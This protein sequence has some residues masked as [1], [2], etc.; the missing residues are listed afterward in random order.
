MWKA[1]GIQGDLPVWK[2]DCQKGQ[3]EL[4]LAPNIFYVFY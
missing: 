2:S 3:D 1:A 4:K